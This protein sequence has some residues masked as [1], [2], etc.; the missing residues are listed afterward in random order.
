MGW[1]RRCCDVRASRVA[2]LLSCSLYDR[3]TNVEWC[4]NKKF[5]AFFEMARSRGSR[6]DDGVRRAVEA[7]VSLQILHGRMTLEMGVYGK[8]VAEDG[9]RM[10]EKSWGVEEAR[11]ARRWSRRGMSGWE[12]EWRRG[13]CV[14]AWSESRCRSR[15]HTQVNA[16][17]PVVP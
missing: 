5:W 9:R 11:H 16:S 10:P 4:K 13:V 15:V 6:A 2:R 1:Q 14:S 8:L 17:I 7:F 3:L 12:K